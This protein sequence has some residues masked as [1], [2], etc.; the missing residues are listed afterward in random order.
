MRIGIPHYGM[1]W[2]LWKRFFQPFGVEVVIPPLNSHRALDLG[3]RYCPEMLCVP[4]KLLFGNY[5]EAL[6]MGLDDLALLGGDNTCRLGYSVQ[7]SAARLQELGYRFRPHS[8]DIFS[9]Q[10]E[11][12]RLLRELA[13]P[14]LPALVQAYRS[15]IRKVNLVEDLEK[16]AHRT[17][18]RELERGRTSAVYQGLLPEIAEAWTGDEIDDLRHKA[19]RLYGGVAQREKAEPV[20][21]AVVGDP[22]SMSEPFFNLGLEEDLGHLGAEV[23]RGF[24]LSN[25][26][27]ETALDR[28]RGRTHYA[29]VQQAA[30]PYV[31]WELGIF[32]RQ[33]VGEA[34]L[35]ARGGIDGLIHVAPFTCTPETVARDIVPRVAREWEVPLLTLTLD[36]HTGRQGQQSRLEAFVDL[37]ERRRRRRHRVVSPRAQVPSG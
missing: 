2:V 19:E 8:F 6:E 16:L 32:A 30:A 18:A 24:W 37:L 9:P 14:S 17:R 26:T 15:L 25:F 21:V 4:C 36:E 12:Y 5:V 20:R 22:Y 27:R 23:Q 7:T 1:M 28:L 33:T 3:T 29:Q 13:T 11:I 10:T 31:R 35:F 34:V